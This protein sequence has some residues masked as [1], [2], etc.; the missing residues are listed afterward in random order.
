MCHAMEV[1]NVCCQA[2]CVFG[3]HW[4]I[5]SI[6]N[7][8]IVF[9]L[10]SNQCPAQACWYENLAT[11][12]TSKLFQSVLYLLRFRSGTG[13]SQSSHV[14]PTLEPNGR[15]RSLFLFSPVS[16]TSRSAWL[17]LSMHDGANS[18]QRRL[19]ARQTAVDIDPFCSLYETARTWS[20]TQLR[21]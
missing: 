17:P 15:G 18:S 14:R 13:R 8:P 2:S 11:R 4:F 16:I 10:F 3:E 6:K 19:S 5:E 12:H 7:L 9:F 1:L 20:A 21:A